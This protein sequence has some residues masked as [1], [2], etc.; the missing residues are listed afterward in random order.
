MIFDHCHHSFFNGST[1]HHP[2][3][4]FF[5]WNFFSL[6]NILKILL[7]V[8]W[9]ASCEAYLNLFR[10]VTHNI[11]F[12]K[13]VVL[14]S[15]N[16]NLI[17]SNRVI[18]FVVFSKIYRR[19]FWVVDSQLCTL[20]F[21]IVDVKRTKKGTVYWKV[22]NHGFVQVLH[23]KDFPHISKTSKKIVHFSSIREVIVQVGNENNFGR[24]DFTLKWI[25]FLFLFDALAIHKSRAFGESNRVFFPEA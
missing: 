9:L 23:K 12:A 6:R 13:S 25:F 15:W 22:F 1:V 7:T 2:F 3:S 20:Q 11:I 10:K 17:E 5:L 24:P 4:I 18:V 16:E 19:V 21:E 8:L 14:E